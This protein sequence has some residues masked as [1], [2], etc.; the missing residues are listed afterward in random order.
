M[1]KL[2]YSVL[3]VLGMFM[4]AACSSGSSSPSD[5]AK[6]YADYLLSGDFDKIVDVCEMGKDV[7]PQEKE[8]GKAL[9][10]GLMK[11]AKET[12]DNQNGGYKAIEVVSE[13][14]SEDGQSADVVIKYT[15][16][17]GSTKDETLGLVMQDGVW[18]LKM[19][20]DK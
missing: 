16:G 4:V 15:F 17:D 18:K 14:I 12:V 9:L 3:L 20:I 11:M 5:A 13:K 10:T 2:V 8:E 1:K 6:K 19:G 7:T